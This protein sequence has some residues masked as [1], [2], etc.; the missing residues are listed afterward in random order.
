MLFQFLFRMAIGFIHRL[1]RL[2]Q[3][4]EVAQLMR[5]V[6]QDGLNRVANG[7]LPIRDHP[8]SRNIQRLLHL[9]G[10]AGK[11]CFTGAEQASGEEDFPR[12]TVA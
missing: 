8:T 10:Q 4:M 1:G 9:A 12:E 3:V 11:F 2:T 5:N 6:W 7:M